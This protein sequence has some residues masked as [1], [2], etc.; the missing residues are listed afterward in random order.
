MYDILADIGN[1][2]GF[3]SLLPQVRKTII[4]RHTLKDLSLTS[5]IL[6]LVTISLFDIY[7]FVNGLIISGLLNVFACSYYGMTIILI[8]RASRK[9]KK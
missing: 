2:I 7:F 5:T 1:L 6:V 9:K 4:N 3:L 8:I